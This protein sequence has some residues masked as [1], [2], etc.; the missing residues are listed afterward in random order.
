MYAKNVA[1][2]DILIS[3]ELNQC[4]AC[5]YT[6]YEYGEVY[7]KKNCKKGD[8]ITSWNTEDHVVCPSCKSFDYYILKENEND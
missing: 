7:N 6:S 3:D 2:M 5:D 4:M 1:K 8:E